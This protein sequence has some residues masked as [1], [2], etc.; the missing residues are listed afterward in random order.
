M[1]VDFSKFGTISGKKYGEP[2]DD[3]VCV[4]GFEKAHSARQLID[5]GDIV[6]AVIDFIEQLSTRQLVHSR[7]VSLFFVTYFLTE[8][9]TVQENPAGAQLPY[10]LD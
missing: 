3:P 6:L 5:F 9:V 2:L 7:I 4:F 8:L 10:S 1:T